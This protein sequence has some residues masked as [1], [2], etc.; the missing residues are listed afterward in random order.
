[1][2]WRVLVLAGLSSRL[3][4]SWNQS[5]LVNKC[6]TGYC[7]IRREKDQCDDGFDAE[8]HEVG[9]T[10][11]SAVWPGKAPFVGESLPVVTGIVR[12]VGFCWNPLKLLSSRKGLRDTGR[13]GG[14]ELELLNGGLGSAGGEGTAPSDAGETARFRKG[15]FDERLRVSP[16]GG[17][18]S[19]ARNRLSATV[20]EID[21]RLVHHAWLC[22]L[23]LKQAVTVD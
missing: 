7:R 19:Y 17:P 18:C 14:K 22:L 5:S 20:Q 2:A 16:G 21:G 15:L 9:P 3:R 10:K 23:F 4:L 1:M 12:D 6:P 13:S 8:S 11:S